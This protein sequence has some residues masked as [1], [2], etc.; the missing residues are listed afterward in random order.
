MQQQIHLWRRGLNLTANGSNCMG[1]GLIN[2]HDVFAGH[3]REEREPS[4]TIARLSWP[5]QTIDDQQVV[6]WFSA[7]YPHHGITVFLAP[8]TISVTTKALQFHRFARDAPRLLDF[9]C[10]RGGD[11]H[12][13]S[14]A[15]VRAIHNP[16]ILIDLVAH[17]STFILAGQGGQRNRCF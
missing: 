17:N 15:G 10:G 13:W 5:Y 6:R 16:S 7:T 12:K 11:M 14:N 3:Q 1:V 8:S 2:A 4:G 9:C